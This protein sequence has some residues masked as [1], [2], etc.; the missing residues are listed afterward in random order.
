MQGKGGNDGLGRQ[1]R[2]RTMDD[3]E[4]CVSCTTFNILARIYRRLDT[5]DQSFRESQNR[6]YWLSRNESIINSFVFDLDAEG[7]DLVGDETDGGIGEDVGAEPGEGGVEIGGKR[8][9]AV[10]G[11]ADD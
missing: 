5:E 2:K 11:H 7:E 8:W 1:Q 9:E 4:R 3:G 6:A 10:I